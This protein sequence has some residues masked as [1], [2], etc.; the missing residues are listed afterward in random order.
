[1]EN[2][3]AEKEKF[4]LVF[5][6]EKGSV[7]FVSKNEQSWRFKK[8]DDERVACQ[9]IMQKIFFVSIKEAQRIINFKKELCFQ[10][11]IIGFQMEKTDFA[12]N[13]VPVEMWIENS[14]QKLF[15]KENDHSI[16]ISKIAYRASGEEADQF[17]SGIHIGHAV[18]R[19][20]KK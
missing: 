15:F 6:T 3:K 8:E 9:P 5:E 16:E 12:K 17:A 20:W 13:V 1:M 2:L 7:Y 4:K 19:I 18:S 10:E 11:K 14:Q